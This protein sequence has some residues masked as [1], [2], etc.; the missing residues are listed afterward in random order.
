MV[1]CVVRVVHPADGMMCVWWRV[2]DVPLRHGPGVRRTRSKAQMV[3]KH[4]V[5]ELPVETAL[6][7]RAREG[8]PGSSSNVD[9]PVLE[10]YLQ[11]IHRGAEMLDRSFDM[12]RVSSGCTG[13]PNKHDTH[14]HTSPARR[15]PSLTSRRSLLLLLLMLLLLLTPR[16]EGAA[17]TMPAHVEK[18]LWFTAPGLGLT[19]S[20][21]VDVFGFNPLVII[22]SIV[23]ESACAGLVGIGDTLIAVDGRRI[24]YDVLRAVSPALISSHCGLFSSF[25]FC[26]VQQHPVP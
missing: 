13:F 4:L 14:A 26:C 2:M 20:R 6:R 11:V 23:P 10:E 16:Q 3:L 12:K 18:E 17:H 7:R 9:D 15:L 21:D 25:S 5:S 24:T 19:F 8:N 1:S 22:K